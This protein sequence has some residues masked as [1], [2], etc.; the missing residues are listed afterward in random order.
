MAQFQS[1]IHWKWQV[2]REVKLPLGL[3]YLGALFSWLVSLST[4]FSLQPIIPL[5]YTLAQL[6]QQLV[7]KEWIF[8]FPVLITLITISHSWISYKI[9]TGNSILLQLFSWTTVIIVAFFALSQLRII[10]LVT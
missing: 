3:T 8:L 2:P 6:E 7:A 4:Y 1:R 10:L 9:Q 5:F